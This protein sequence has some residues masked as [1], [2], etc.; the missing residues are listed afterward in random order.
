MRA[1]CP[2]GCGARVC[3]A[4]ALSEALAMGVCPSRGE[5]GETCARAALCLLRLLGGAAAEL[6]GNAFCC[7]LGSYCPGT[8][9]GTRTHPATQ[10]YVQRPHSDP[11][12]PGT[13]GQAPGGTDSVSDML[14]RWEALAFSENRGNLCRCR[15]CR[16]NRGGQARARGGLCSAGASPRGL[17]SH[18]L[19]SALAEG[20]QR[21]RVGRREETREE[22][23]GTWVSLFLNEEEWGR[24]LLK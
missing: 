17:A 3:H 14:S 2:P 10:T 1:T 18:P 16:E 12:P 24:R 8:H 9:T 5:A 6:D 20:A 7:I 15:N 21:P 22:G 13:V 23:R 11:R 4:R 19:T